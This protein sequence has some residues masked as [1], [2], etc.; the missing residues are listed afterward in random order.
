MINIQ[1]VAEDRYPVMTE[2]EWNGRTFTLPYYISYHVYIS[3]QK[4]SRKHFIEGY[5]LRITL[6][7]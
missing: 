4:E 5:Q 3:S 6:K 7:H 2:D 1:Q